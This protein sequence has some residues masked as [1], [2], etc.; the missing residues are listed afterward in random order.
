MKT[1]YSLNSAPTS[2][3]MLPRFRR[4]KTSMT[5]IT[6]KSNMKI[7]RGVLIGP[8]PPRRHL[9]CLGHSVDRL[10]SASVVVASRRESQRIAS[11]EEKCV[12]CYG[13][14]PPPVET[15]CHP[16]Q[17]AHHRVVCV[18]DASNRLLRLGSRLRHLRLPRPPPTTGHFR[19]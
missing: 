16:L 12:V 3:Q 18:C 14:P 6:Y 13:A 1:L 10:C 11:V 4:F 8:P 19:H 9:C 17:L 15:A 5:P 2:M 7:S